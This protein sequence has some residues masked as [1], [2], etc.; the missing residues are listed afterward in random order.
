L[1]FEE[2]ILKRHVQLGNHLCS[3]KPVAI[4]QYQSS[5]N[6]LTVPDT[7]IDP[8]L[9]PDSIWHLLLLMFMPYGNQ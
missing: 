8:F 1:Y 9:P 5:L 6:F 3:Q 7:S 4:G 2:S